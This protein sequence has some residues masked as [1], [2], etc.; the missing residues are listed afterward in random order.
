MPARVCTPTFLP[1]QIFGGFDARR[2]N[3]IVTQPVGQGRNDLEIGAAGHRGENRGAAGI[4]R[5]DV[6][7]GQ[8]GHQHRRLA[9]K[10][11]TGVYAH[12]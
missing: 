4:R 9:N 1:R 2:G 6:T 7:R 5:Q 8:R 10:N 12:T 11:R 3:D